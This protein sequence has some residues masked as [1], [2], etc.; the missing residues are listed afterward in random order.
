MLLYLGGRKPGDAIPK[1]LAQALD[2][3]GSVAHVT[4]NVESPFCF[5]DASEKSQAFG[6]I[7]VGVVLQASAPIH[8][9]VRALA[10]S[11][12]STCALPPMPRALARMTRM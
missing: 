8:P 4:G 12:D 3:V 1:A 6:R 5:H 2:L 7:D 10:L 9:S 11:S